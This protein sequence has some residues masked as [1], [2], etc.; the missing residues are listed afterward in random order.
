MKRQIADIIL[1]FCGIIAISVTLLAQDS[2]STSLFTVKAQSILTS[3]IY[4]SSSQDTLWT[5][6]LPPFVGRAILRGTAD[7]ASL[8]SI[9]FELYYSNRNFGTNQPF[10]Q[11][12]ISPRLSDWLTLHAG[13]FSHPISD[14]T[15]GD[16]RVLGGGID[17]HPGNIHLSAAYGIIRH[18][19]TEQK[20]D[21]VL[22]FPGE[23]KRLMMSAKLGYDHKNGNY[24]FLNMMKS[25]DD[26]A[27]GNGLTQISPMDNMVASVNTGFSVIH[28][29]TIKGEGAIS[30]TNANRSASRLENGFQLPFNIFTPTIS[31]FIDGAAKLSI[32]YNPQSFWSIKTDAQWVGPGFVTQGFMQLPNDVF[33]ITV[34]PTMQLFEKTVSVRG[35]IGI[36]T[37]NLRNNRQS[38]TQRIIGMGNISW[39]YEQWWGID[40]SY[41]NYGINSRHDNDTLRLQ[42]VVQNI[43][44]SPRV[45]FEAWDSYHVIN[46]VFSVQDVNDNN[47]ITQRLTNSAAVSGALTHTI[48]MKNSLNFTTS[49]MSTD[50]KN[51]QLNVSVL[52]FTETVGYTFIENVLD[53]SVMA[54]IGSIKTTEN[55]NQLLARISANYIT[56]TIGT[57]SLIFS[58]NSYDYS[59]ASYNPA[60]RELLGNFQWVMNL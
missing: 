46:A 13:Y 24:I 34:S 5:P 33:D 15:F 1:I 56:K 9:P 31:S 28:G 7:I 54:G 51:N 17:F 45:M 14:F 6:R 30:A 3:E 44:I 12:G 4:T 26:T 10:N 41:S 50:V 16:L 52:N 11:F 23:Y 19:R 58:L 57:F 47:V 53:A 29:L 39:N 27:S 35:S 2:P 21:S 20:R 25:W 59:S 55:E 32:H 48:T 36:R 22:V 38:A 60:F 18:E 37:N 49:F 8:V 40:G 42:N 43:V